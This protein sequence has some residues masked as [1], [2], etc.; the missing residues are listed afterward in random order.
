[1]LCLGKNNAV[2]GVVSGKSSVITGEVC[3]CELSIPQV[4]RMQGRDS[5]LVSMVALLTSK[6]LLGF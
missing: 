1:M 4:W 5:G 2:T 3:I 6:H